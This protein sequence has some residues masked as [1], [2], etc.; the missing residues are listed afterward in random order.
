MPPYWHILVTLLS[1]LILLSLCSAKLPELENN[2][3]TLVS[4]CSA[5]SPEDPSLLFVRE[6]FMFLFARPFGLKLPLCFLSENILCFLLL[7]HMP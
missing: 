4:F 5:I 2:H 7:G 1:L 3:A 6:H